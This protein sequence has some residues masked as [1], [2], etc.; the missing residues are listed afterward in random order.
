MKILT[1][2][3]L[4]FFVNI[5]CLV[6]QPQGF[7]IA[8][9][10]S[11]EKRLAT[12]PNDTNR[13]NTLAEIA[14]L[15]SNT[16]VEKSILLGEEALMLTRK[17][18]Y[19][20]G[21]RKILAPLSFQYSISGQ[22]AKGLELALEGKERYKDLLNVRSNYCNMAQL[23]YQFQGDYK[24]CLEECHEN[25]QLFNN[26]LEIEFGL[27]DKWASYMT[28]SEM[29]SNMQQADSAL[30]YAFKSLS[31]AQSIKFNTGHFVGYAHN[32]LGQA[33]LTKNMPDTAIAHFHI[34]RTAMTQINE[35]FALQETQVYLAKAMQQKGALD[36][37]YYYAKTAY[38]GVAI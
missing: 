7:S 5:L 14:V 13:I 17:L 31:Y 6:A 21:F 10:D 22:W 18:N 1:L 23:A 37:V 36:S 16:N 38:D 33:Y 11:L 9:L 2:T 24:R 19:A 26:H 30:I 35:Q 12:Q 20:N 8:V 28:A 34:M 3:L 32:A 27:V 29:Y 15:Y 4:L 25:I